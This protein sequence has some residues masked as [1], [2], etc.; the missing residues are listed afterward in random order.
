MFEIK[1]KRSIKL[2]NKKFAAIKEMNFFNLEAFK[3]N[4]YIFDS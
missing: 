3:P 1:E 2:K 4:D